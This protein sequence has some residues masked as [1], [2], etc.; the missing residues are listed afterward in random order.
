MAMTMDPVGWL[1]K[2]P[3][4]FTLATAITIGSVILVTLVLFHGMGIHYVLDYHKSGVVRLRE[5]RP[6]VLTAVLLFGSAVF[7]MLTLHIAGVIAWSLVLS[8]LGLIAKSGDAIYF[9]ANAYTTL[10]YGS[11]DMDTRYRIISPII[12]ISGLFTFAWTTSALVTIVTTHNALLERLHEERAKQKQLRLNL[13]QAVESA[14]MR[15]RDE[16]EHESIEITRESVGAPLYGRWQRWRD[17]RA[18]MRAIREEYRRERDKLVAAESAAEDALGVKTSEAATAGGSASAG[19][20]IDAAKSAS[21]G[22]VNSPGAAGSGSSA[23]SLP[24]DHTAT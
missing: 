11:V 9:C 23:S 16:E 12:G 5:G 24:P 13:K 7:L 1:Q 22:A 10:G 6:H 20:N 4:Q 18:H 15:E 14:R 2:I 3:P 21:A 17:E 19:A 8:Q